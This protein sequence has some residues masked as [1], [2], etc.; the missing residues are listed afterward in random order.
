MKKLEII[1]A[2][3]LQTKGWKWVINQFGFIVKIQ[4]EE[5]DQRLKSGQWILANDEQIV[6]DFIK[7]NYL[8]W[9]PRIYVPNYNNFAP[10]QGYT[11][12]ARLLEA[13]LIS[14]GI[15]FT[16]TLQPDTDLVL[17]IN[18]VWA[19][20]NTGQLEKMA[21]EAKALNKQIAMFTMFES[22][23]WIT[24][25]V[26]EMEHLD[27]LIVPSQWNK[28]TL[29][30]QGYTKPIYVCPLP[31]EDKYQL[32][33]R[34][35]KRD[36]FTFLTYNGCD[37]RKGFPEYLDAFFEEFGEDEDVKYIQKTRADDSANVNFNPYMERLNNTGKRKFVWIREDMN[38]NQLMALHAKT[39]CFVFPSKGEGWGYTPIEAILTG[40]PVIITE[41]H[42]FLDW[43]N[44]ACLP[45]QTT[46][47]PATFSILGEIQ[48]DVGFWF[49]PDK[50]DLKRQMRFIYETWKK[51]GREAE[52]FK[53][54]LVERENLL[55]AYNKNAVSELFTII[56]QD[57]KIIA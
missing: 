45:V 17:I 27:F 21:N 2:E 26:N 8:P 9:K 23:H 48:D 3:Q 49:K 32:Q 42:S 47:E 43:I 36:T 44:P 25:H 37:F 38:T 24:S 53:Q 14:K 10:N 56:L 57:R 50:E 33:E 6:S 51:E 11:H 31:I 55:K 29:V 20:A 35:V 4:D 5:A 41:A 15:E 30:K 46:L 40:N 13:G 18:S 19:G 54:P 34:P 1:T 52:I 12:F 28:E 39:D 7:T 16:T 22:D